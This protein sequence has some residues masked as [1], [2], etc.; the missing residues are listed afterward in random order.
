[1]A[2]DVSPN[3]DVVAAMEA[4][5]YRCEC[6]YPLVRGVGVGVGKVLWQTFCTRCGGR[7]LGR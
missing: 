3:L 4:L 6:E 5:S 1:M 2:E 7:T